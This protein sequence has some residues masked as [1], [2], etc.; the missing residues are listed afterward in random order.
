MST[1]TSSAVAAGD[2][3]L[4]SDI[5][6]IMTDILVN[7]GDY[8]TT[9]GSSNAFTLTLDS[10]IT[11]YTEGM[12]VRFK[13]D[14][15]NTGASTLNINSIGAANIVKYGSTSLE[16]N[17]I[18]SGKVYEVMYDGTNFQLSNSFASSGGG[19]SSLSSTTYT[20]GKLSSVDLDGTTWTL[21]YDGRGEPA[22]FND[23]ASTF[24][25]T[26]NNNGKITL[27]SS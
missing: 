6:A 19:F 18:Q 1:I 21:T 17:D 20:K 16:A 12:V 4:A 22:T 10:R 2:D 5:N 25:V 24:T 14:R 15:A 23:G 7:A 9:G 26:R 8:A 11:S 3:I 13:G 27:L